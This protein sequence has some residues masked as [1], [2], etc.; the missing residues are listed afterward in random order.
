MRGIGGG[1]RADAM[2]TKG[3]TYDQ[4][5]IT[6]SVSGVSSQ[7]DVMKLSNLYTKG[8]PCVLKRLKVGTLDLVYNEVGAGDGVAVKD[9]I[10][11]TSVTYKVFNNVDNVEVSI[12]P[13]S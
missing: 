9:L 8:G 7:V 1:N 5:K 13:P 12:S 4:I 10:V 2:I 11:G 6:A 3:G